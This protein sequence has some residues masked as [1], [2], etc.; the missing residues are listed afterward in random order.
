MTTLNVKVVDE[1]LSLCDTFEKKRSPVEVRNCSTESGARSF[2]ATLLVSLERNLA[3]DR[4][5]VVTIILLNER[6]GCLVAE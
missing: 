2:V 1:N 5:D 3:T 4:S 6:F